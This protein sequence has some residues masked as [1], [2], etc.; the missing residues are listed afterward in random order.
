MR[1]LEPEPS[2]VR[3]PNAGSSSPLYPQS[4][5]WMLDQKIPYIGRLRMHQNLSKRQDPW[6][7]NCFDMSQ[8][9]SAQ[10]GLYSLLYFLSCR[11]QG[12]KSH[13]RN[14]VF[15]SDFVLVLT[16]FNPIKNLN[17]RAI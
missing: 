5:L 15:Y 12:E 1:Q 11:L 3:E 13:L 2:T 6:L 9:A 17:F 8:E 16:F 10:L 14:L 7:N 4:D